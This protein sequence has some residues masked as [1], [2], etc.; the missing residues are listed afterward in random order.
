MWFLSFFSKND[1]ESLGYFV[2]I[3]FLDPKR[4]KLD[5]NSDFRHVR[6]CQDLSRRTSTYCK[7]AEILLFFQ[8]LHLYIFIN[9]GL[10]LFATSTKAN[11]WSLEM[12]WMIEIIAVGLFSYPWEKE[13]AIP[14][15]QLLIKAIADKTAS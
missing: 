8:I 2:K 12:I 3:P 1:A 4:A 7:P 9:K 6:T 15:S 5:Q 10:R 13:G 14:P 11:L